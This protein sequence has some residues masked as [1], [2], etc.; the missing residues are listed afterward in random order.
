MNQVIKEVQ[1]TRVRKVR[2]VQ[3]VLLE[4]HL[5][6]KV[7]LAHRGLLG[8]KEKMEQRENEDKLDIKG[9]LVNRGLEERKVTQ[10]R[11]ASRVILEKLVKVDKK[12]NR[13]TMEIQATTARKES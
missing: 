6:L 3:L 13:G 8:Y 5:V 12:V 7:Y 11:E 1:A 4:V 2:I 9:T 10:E